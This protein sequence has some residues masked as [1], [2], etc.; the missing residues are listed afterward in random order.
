MDGRAERRPAATCPALGADCVSTVSLRSVALD[1]RGALFALRDYTFQS[2]VSIFVVFRAQLTTR[3]A[4]VTER[5]TKKTCLELLDC[6]TAPPF[7]F[8]LFLSLVWQDA[9]G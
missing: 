6:P 3:L 4:I 1:G 5:D 8:P 9:C 7:T 2:N